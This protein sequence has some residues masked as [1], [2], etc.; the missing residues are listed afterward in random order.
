MIL[1]II[2]GTLIVFGESLYQFLNLA[3]VKKKS[4]ETSEGQ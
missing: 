3:V 4:K 2:F 1:K